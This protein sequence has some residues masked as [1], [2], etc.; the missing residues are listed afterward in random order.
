M[1]VFF[2]DDVR[3]GPFVSDNWQQFYLSIDVLIA[4]FFKF[5]LLLD[6]FFWP[7]NF[8]QE[9]FESILRIALQIDAVV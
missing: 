2:S 1:I 4:N 7:Q 3:C 6:Q 5:T 8:E 9:S